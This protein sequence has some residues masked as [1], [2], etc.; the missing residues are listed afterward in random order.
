M[1]RDAIA[2]QYD[3]EKNSVTL[4]E[5]PNAEGNY[6]PGKI[7]FQARKGKSIDLEK[8]RESIAATRL[9]GGTSMRV[10]WLEITA[11]G[12]VVAAGPELRLKVSGTGQELVL[13]E[14]PAAREVWQ[15][16]REAQARG[17]R[18][19]SVTGK[20]QGWN[21]KFPDVLRALA[22]DAPGGQK[23]P[24]LLVTGFEVAGK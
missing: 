20:V 1:A 24:L 14:E 16:L 5:D 3:V 15:R 23:P 7:A 2:R 8:L 9:S 18:I 13:G 17:A 21:G 22:P 10:D 4:T 6:R 12:E 11:L 19:T